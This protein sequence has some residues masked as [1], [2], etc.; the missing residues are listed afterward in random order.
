MLLFA[1]GVNYAQYVRLQMIL[2]DAI[3]FDSGGNLFIQPS[4]LKMKI[5][6]SD[7]QFALNYCIDAIIQV[8]AQIGDVENI[9]KPPDWE[10]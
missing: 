7:T 4:L 5:T 3:S 8:E 2:H 10:Y 9:P 1:I 6:K